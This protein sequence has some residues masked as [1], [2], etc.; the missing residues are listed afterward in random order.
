MPQAGVPRVALAVPP[1]PE[2][3]R[4]ALL[5]GVAPGQGARRGAAWRTVLCWDCRLV[6]GWGVGAC[7]TPPTRIGTAVEPRG[8]SPDLCQGRGQG[9]WV[10]VGDLVST[11]AAPRRHRCPHRR[12]TA[13][14]PC[15]FLTCCRRLLPST[16][17]RSSTACSPGP[18]STTSLLRGTRW[19][20]RFPRRCKPST[21]GWVAGW[22]VGCG[23]GGGPRCRG[24]SGGRVL[25][26]MTEYSTALAV[27]GRKAGPAQLPS[28][29]T[30]YHVSVVLFATSL[31]CDGDGGVLCCPC[32]FLHG[33]SAPAPPPH[34]PLQA[35]GRPVAGV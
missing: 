16:S 33:A 9:R 6:P 14:S 22:L 18:A 35:S 20:S 25:R 11:V 15:P 34:L 8:P 32:V 5:Q 4:A 13:P 30:T 2:A 3:L 28:P 1:G 12:P 10:A 26:A 29:H 27:R 7:V 21:G 17:L 24:C 23:G 19:G 31:A